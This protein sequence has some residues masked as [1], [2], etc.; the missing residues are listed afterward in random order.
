MNT[1]KASAL[2]RRVHPSNNAASLK[3]YSSARACRSNA[4][5]LPPSLSGSMRP[6][7]GFLPSMG[8]CGIRK[9]HAGLYTGESTPTPKP[10]GLSQISKCIGS[11][12]SNSANTP[13]TI[14]KFTLCPAL[15]SGFS[16]L[17]AEMAKDTSFYSEWPSLDS[18]TKSYALGTYEGAMA[19]AL[20]TKSCLDSPAI[21][22]MRCQSMLLLT[23]G[24]DGENLTAQQRRQC[25]WVVGMFGSLIDAIDNHLEAIGQG[26]A[27]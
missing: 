7:V 3:V 9:D 10:G 8:V 17:S 16:E 25:G 2:A 27:I 24:L 5:L 13:C 15:P 21:A 1:Q 11:T 12:M 26:D 20:A 18:D 22:L 23:L 14:P 4:E 6:A 19:Y